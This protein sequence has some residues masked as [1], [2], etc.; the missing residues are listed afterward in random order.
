VFLRDIQYL[1]EVVLMVLMWASPIVYSWALVDANVHSDALKELYLA[2][3]VTL[4]VL[5][6]QRTFWT[7]AG[8]DAYPDH[9]LERI[10]IALVISLVLLVIGHRIFAR[11]EG[12]FA[13][14]L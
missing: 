6:F 3:P 7:G 2:N 8:A 14:E 13:Q 4:A 12:N 11:V 5:G 1:V 9:L 10:L